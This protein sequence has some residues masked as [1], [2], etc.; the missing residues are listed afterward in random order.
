MEIA[1]LNQTIITCQ[2]LYIPNMDHSIVFIKTLSGWDNYYLCFTCEKTLLRHR[3]VKESSEGHT[4]NGNWQCHLWE[5]VGQET[6]WVSQ[7]VL[8]ICSNALQSS[9]P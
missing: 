5:L 1:N 3:E 4:V 6:G 7:P 2:T 9:V 8:E